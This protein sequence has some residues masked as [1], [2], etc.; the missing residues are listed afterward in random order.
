MDHHIWASRCTFKASVLLRR[1]FCL[2][3]LSVTGRRF[4]KF[5]CFV[6]LCYSRLSMVLLWKAKAV[7]K[8]LPRY[9]A[10]TRKTSRRREMAQESVLM[11]PSQL[12]AL[13]TAE[14]IVCSLEFTFTEN[15][16]VHLS[17]MSSFTFARNA[18]PT[19]T[20]QSS[21][22]DSLDYSH[23]WLAILAVLLLQRERHDRQDPAA[24]ALFPD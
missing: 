23:P 13:K 18:F 22:F 11:L 1:R 14:K 10:M 7:S 20:H 8:L 16:C 3:S 12:I 19:R 17:C 15:T 24:V 21:S 6:R 9:T 5:S 2:N 4:T